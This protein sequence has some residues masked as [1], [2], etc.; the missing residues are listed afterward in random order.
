MAVDLNYGVGVEGKNLVLKTLGRVYVKVKDRKYELLFRPEDLQNLINGDNIDSNDS[1]KGTSVYFINSALDLPNLEYP[2]DGCLIV[3]KD[4]SFYFTEKG[5]YTQ[6]PLAFNVDELTLT[7]LNV[8]DQ[9][10]FTGSNPPLVISEPIFIQNLNADKIDGYDASAFGIK[11]NSENITGTWTFNNLKL[12]NATSSGVLKNTDESIYID[13]QTGT[14][15]CKEIIADN[16]N[17]P[18]EDPTYNLVSGIGNEVWVGSEIDILT[19][20]E[21]VYTASDN[22]ATLM[23][24]AYDQGYLP[25]NPADDIEW[26][27]EDFWIPLFFTTYN[28]DSET[29]ILKDFT[30]QTVLDNANAKLSPYYNITEFF[31]LIWA[32]QTGDISN[33]TGIDYQLTTYASVSFQLVLPNMIIKDNLGNIGVVLSRDNDSIVVR[34]LNENN[35]FVGNKL[36]SI[37]FV[38]HPS[39]ICLRSEDPSL[40]ILKNVLDLNDPSIYFGELSKI[41]PNKSGIGMLLNGSVPDNKVA[42]NQLDSLRNYTHTSEIN[43]ENP[44]IKWQQINELNEDGSG[45]LSKGQIRW[46]SNNDLVIDG[47]DITNSRIDNSGITDS[48]FEAGNVLINTDGSGNIGTYIEFNATDVTKN[49]PMGSAGGDLTGNYP[50]PTIGTSKITSDKIADSAITSNKIADDSITSSKIVDGTIQGVDLANNIITSDK[51]ADGAVNTNDLANSAITTDK[52]ANKSVNRDKLTDELWTLI[53]QAADTSELE[54]AINDL[55]TQV[56]ELET[57]VTTN[58]S[59]ISSLSSQVNELETDVATNATNISTNA[60]NISSLT[61]QVN[62]L[63]ASVSTN[64]SNISS[65]STNL[66]SLSNTV[67]GHT[68]SINNLSSQLSNLTSS[69]NEDYTNLEARVTA[70]ETTVGTLN[71]RLENRLNGN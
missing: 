47:S 15:T 6:I 46:S 55:K 50:N 3:S 70:L 29:F 28:E 13:F 40:S 58:T 62:N 59:N 16:L 48:S 2:G 61:T 34:M 37:G 64:T 63:N 8:S 42:D 52:I 18:E 53:E 36:I 60:S 20:S 11:N 12:K 45:Y 10:I 71:T 51:I 67:S 54:N 35:N 21:F 68:T 31:P 56:S 26:T 39:G 14:I 49:I 43:I 22:T 1:T 41:D 25:S 4:G 7:R 32:L 38:T 44:Y 66:S 19:S 33:F 30:N 17:E 5:S 65:L 24:N 69:V 27:L 9:I 23:H 57:D